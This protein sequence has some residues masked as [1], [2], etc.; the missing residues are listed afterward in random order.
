MSP[1]YTPITL[2]MVHHAVVGIGQNARVFPLP[3]DARM[4]TC[5]TVLK[6]LILCAFCGSR[7]DPV[8]VLKRDS[9]QCGCFGKTR[10]QPVV[11]VKKWLLD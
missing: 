10:P 7:R 8:T 3:S 1:F 11:N 6:S 4:L 5:D 2:Q 9:V